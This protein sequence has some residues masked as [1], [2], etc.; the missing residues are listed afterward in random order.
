MQAKI[1]ALPR[2]CRPVV[3]QPAVELEEKPLPVLGQAVGRGKD[4]AAGG[5]ERPLPLDAVFRPVQGIFQ[6]LGV[7]SSLTR[8]SSTPRLMLCLT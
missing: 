1:S 7:R 6:V 5:P 8:Y 2:K 3:E 4:C